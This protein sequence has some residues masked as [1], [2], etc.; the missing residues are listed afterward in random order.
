M[1][2]CNDYLDEPQ[3]YTPDETPVL[4]YLK[5]KDLSGIILSSYHMKDSAECLRNLLT[6]NIPISAWVEDHRILKIISHYNADQKKLS[7]FDSSYSTLPGLEVGNYLIGK[8]HKNIAYISTFNESPWS[9]NRLAGLKKAARSVPDIR[10]FPY[11]CIC[12]K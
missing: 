3:F 5:C 7:F 1:S 10:V 12:L 6:L 2:C 8:G 11:V 9:Q 4:H